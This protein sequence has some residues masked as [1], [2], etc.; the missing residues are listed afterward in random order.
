M[1]LGLHVGLLKEQ[2]LF[3]SL[4][5]AFG[6]LSAIWVALSSLKSLIA[7]LY[8]KAGSYQPEASFLRRRGGGGRRER[9]TCDQD[10]K[11]I[12]IFIEKELRLKEI[13]LRL[14]L[15]PLLLLNICCILYQNL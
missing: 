5:P 7:T 6:S 4:L 3:L 15:R 1:Q 8:V 11:K 13:T 14:I 9:G 12:N 2:R 10:A